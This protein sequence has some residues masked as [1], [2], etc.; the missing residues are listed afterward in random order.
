MNN[1]TIKKI[2]IISAILIILSCF[3]PWWNLFC[4][5]IPDSGDRSYAL[6]ISNPLFDSYIK[7]FITYTNDSSIIQGDLILQGVLDSNYTAQIPLLICVIVTLIGGIIGLISF[8]K[9]KII[10]ISGLIALLG[11]ILYI[12]FMATGTEP[13]GIDP[14]YFTDNNLVPIFGTFSREIFFIVKI[15][16]ATDIFLNFIF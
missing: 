1:G 9:K 6:F 12:I 16:D 14:N 5:V 11:V 2:V 10:L 15:G 4:E 7:I 13:S 3:L 8:G